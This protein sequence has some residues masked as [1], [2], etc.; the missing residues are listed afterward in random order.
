MWDFAGFPALSE[1]VSQAR[2]SC[3]GLPL[4]QRGKHIIKR[5]WRHLSSLFLAVDK[6]GRRCRHAEFISRA[7]MDLGDL[8]VEALIGEAG[9]EGFLA[10][11]GLLEKVG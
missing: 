11:S 10:H 1:L 7:V 4:Q 5:L 3:G 8:V 6:E 9:I 2:W